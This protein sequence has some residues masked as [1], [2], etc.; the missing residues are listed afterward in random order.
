M[1]DFADR[2]NRLS[3][4][5][6]ELLLERLRRAGGRPAAEPGIPRRADPRRA[7]L[8]FAQRRLWFLDQ[9]KQEG[10]G[11]QIVGAIRLE[12]PLNRAAL[13]QSLEAIVQRHE[14]L[15][16]TIQVV[17]GEPMQV[18]APL[19]ACPLPGIDWSHLESAEQET[20]IKQFLEDE[21]HRGFDLA[22][23]PLLRASLLMRGD[24]DHVLTLAMHHIVADGWSGGVLR[25]ELAEFYRAFCRGQPPQLRE[26]PA[27]YADFAEWQR[28]HLQ[29]EEL[30]QQLTYWRERLEH[31]PA[32]RLPADRPRPESSTRRGGVQERWL[33][34]AHR[35]SLHQFNRHEGV[36]L[37]MT[38]L[39]CFQ[40]LLARYSGQT[41]I[42]VGTPVANRNRSELE[43][44]IGFFVNTLV[45]RTDCSGNPTFRQLLHHVRETAVGA[46]A[47]QDLPFERLVEELHPERD[48]ER[49]PLFQVAFAVQNAPRE[50]LEM[51]DLV[52]SPLVPDV[53]TTR[54]DL[55]LHVWE[56]ERGLRLVA[57]F[58]RD[59]FQPE[60]I[61]R[62]L[63]HLELLIQSALATPE[64]SIW[65]LPLL[66]PAERRQ[67]LSEWNTA[68]SDFA[69]EAGLVELFRRQVCRTPEA[70]SVVS[71]DT[72]FT[73]REL[74]ERSEQIA[75]RLLQHGVGP[76]TPVAL[77]LDPSPE[78]IA[79]TLGI[80]KAGGAYVP[81]DFAAPPARWSDVLV[82][83]GTRLVL[84]QRSLRDR[85]APLTELPIVD[86]DGDL[87]PA[88]AA[89]V[90]F[91]PIRAD[92]LA[93]VM[94]TS[95][96]MGRPKGIAV[97][98]R[99]VVRLVQ[100]TNYVQI[101]PRDVVAQLA[102]YAFDA[103]TFEVWGALLSGARLAIMPKE[104]A[105][106]P[107]QFH[108]H[109][110]HHGT[111][112]VF[113]TTSLFHHLARHDPDIFASLRCL[114]V[115]GEAMDPRIAG[116]V[117]AAGRPQ[118]LV[119]VY[120]P[121]E[122]ATFSTFYAIEEVAADD[123]SVPIG[124]PVSNTEL[125]VLDDRM[126]PVPIGVPGELYLGGDGLARGYLQDPRLTAE[127]F[128]PHLFSDQSGQRLYATGDVVCFRANG[129]LEFLG[130]RDHQ[131]KLRGFRIELDEIERLLRGHPTVEDAAVLMQ[132]DNSQN[133][134]LVACVQSRED[135]PATVEALLRL[136]RASLPS[137]MVPA[138][139][140]FLPEFP[141]NAYGK[142]DRGALDD[143]AFS[144]RPAVA[145]NEG[146]TGTG[147][148]TPIEEAVAEIFAELLSLD[149]V[150]LHTSF[151][152]LGGHSLLATQLASRLRDVFQIELPLS[153]LF[154]TP[155]VAAASAEVEQLLR[156]DQ[157]AVSPPLQATSRQD[158]APA[159]FAQ[160]RLWFLHRFQPEGGAWH[161]PL[162]AELRGPLDI[163]A[164]QCSL[165]EIVRRHEA[166]RTGFAEVS[167]QPFQVIA[168][169]VR[170]PVRIVD[171][172]GLAEPAR[173]EAVRQQAA[174]E[175][176]E[177]FEL[178]TAP[179][180]R[181]C[182]LRLEDE[183]SVLSITLHHIV[184]DGWSLGILSRELAAC[185]EAFVE[186][187]RP[188]LL[189]LP[190]QY[191]DFAEWQR[192]WL[193]ESTDPQQLNYWR[194][195]LADLPLLQL[196]TDHP[197]PATLNEA[198]S[199]VI[200]QLSPELTGQLRALSRQVGTTLYMTML[201]A[202]D[203]LLARYTGQTDIVIGTPIANRNRSE[204]EGLIGFFVNSLVMR[205]D[206]SGD[207][208]FCELLRRVR[209]TALGAYAHQDLPFERLVEELNPE[210]HFN[211][212]PLFQVVFAVQNAWHEPLHLTGLD[213]RPIEFDVATA[214]YDLQLDVWEHA[215]CLQLNAFFNCDLFER[216]TIQ[217]LM[218][219]LETLL[220][221][222]VTDP[223]RRL[224]EFPLLLDQDHQWL[225]ER[226]IGQPI[227]ERP[228]CLHQRFQVQAERTPEAVAVVSADQQLSYGELNAWANRIA[229]CLRERSVGP[230][231]AVGLCVDRTPGLV[232]GILGI[233]KAG[234]AYVPLEPEWPVER[235][236]YILAETKAPVLL[237][238]QSLEGQL[239]P[240][241]SNAATA[242]S[243][244]Q[245][246]CLD[247][248][249][250]SQADAKC[251]ASGVRPENLAYVIY[252]SGSTGHP[253]GVLVTHANVDRLFANTAAWFHFDDRDVWTLFH[254]FAFD[255]S[256]WELWGALLHGGRLVILPYLVS[257][258]PSEFRHWLKQHG[259]TVLNQTPTAFSQL[260]AVTSPD[261][262]PDVRC[263]VFGGEALDPAS[264]GAWLDGKLER[265]RLVN[266]YGITETTVH[267]T[268]S[269][270]TSDAAFQNGSPIG[271]P[272]P[273][274]QIHLLDRWGNQ[275]PIGC[276]GEICVGGAG[277]ARGYVA[278]AVLTA[279]KFIPDP[280]S[281]LPGQ[282][283]YRSG[284][285]ARYR[286]DGSLEFL[287]RCDDQVK[288]RGF[289]VELGE[290]ESELITSDA[291]REAA[292]I[293][294]QEVSGDDRLV[295]YV[296][297][298]IDHPWIRQQLTDEKRR[299]TSHW[300]EL[301]DHVYREAGSSPDPELNLAGW[302]SSY[303]GEPIPEAAMREQIERTV[304]RIQAFQTQRILEIGCGTGLLL[305]RLAPNCVEY[306][307]T[308][309][310]AVALEQL[311]DHLPE[312]VTLWLREADDFTGISPGSIDVVVLNS[313]VQYFPDLDYL[314]RVLEGAAR[315][316][317]SG[318]AIFVGDV[319]SLP[320]EHAFQASVELPRAAD[321]TTLAEVR[322]RI[323]QQLNQENE[324]LIDPSFFEGLAEHLPGLRAIRVE[325]KRGRDHNELTQFRYDVTM[326]F[327][328]AP[329]PSVEVEWLDWREQ[330]W[331]IAEIRH[332]LRRPK[333]RA[334]GL[335]CVDNARS[336]AAVRAVELLQDLPDN[337]VA[338]A[339]EQIKRQVGLQPGVDPELLW[340]LA[341]ELPYRVV[342]RWTGGR[343]PGDF[344]VAFLPVAEAMPLCEPE[345]LLPPRAS[346]SFG[347]DVNTPWQPRFAARLAQDLRSELRQ[348]LP[349][350][351][352]PSAIVVLDRFPLTSRGKLDRQALPPPDMSR[353]GLDTSFAAPRSPLEATLAQIWREVLHVQQVGI[354]DN[355]FDLGGHSL[356]A[357][358]V[359][360]RVRDICRVELPLR[361]L[362]ESPT[363]AELA[364]AVAIHK[365]AEMDN[366]RLA[367]SL[368]RIQ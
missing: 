116:S 340:A 220:R 258:S 241:L 210:R 231:T 168:Q 107:Q 354:H 44:L 227:V 221:S 195:Q 199:T 214:R 237:T 57:T 242:S 283:L 84:T 114:L 274:L 211:R 96:S 331:S 47:H 43:G 87:A 322:E 358:Q 217:R 163:R 332:R 12:G 196:P 134:R 325:P 90:V 58:D 253:K 15:R 71:D 170:C 361:S 109:L 59:L 351:M 209:S 2:I 132:G 169:T 156:A 260:G 268:H 348:R 301:Y 321:S 254:S 346:E 232:A 356:L 238:S 198:G 144:R 289:R 230:E 223:N 20:R 329:L 288:I 83:S 35:K 203:L 18:I 252:T 23:G 207:P 161:V 39:A 341:D 28:S 123:V 276:P 342:I 191:A 175:Q 180:V 63:R 21:Q 91:P 243:Q 50:R 75:R 110:R 302:V 7:P 229:N 4:E 34:D 225:T 128:V 55:E 82:E 52:L 72:S 148:R 245:W 261:D 60:T 333:A 13:E 307:A 367:E 293:H 194:D 314:Q 193:E 189:E 135:S 127:K 17:D 185:Y 172:R 157:F 300:R 303:T 49:N 10:G 366:S 115:G 363:I 94:Y 98:Q 298:D 357:T 250:V 100:N 352:I 265:P 33:S 296:T 299:L 365:A 149:H 364:V 335:S 213:V 328:T 37:Y 22:K 316:V 99:A 349:D 355:F 36:T 38:L 11:Y 313:L 8:S 278:D 318:G 282:R 67:L 215:D 64:A 137:Y 30:Q 182:V 192:R 205:T 179:L 202:F 222:I 56:Q 29:G 24:Q 173:E 145:G 162:M 124:R 126:S 279:E 41:D 264:L 19:A 234:G 142:V 216:T 125:Y 155:S 350:Y 111:S 236:A 165:D 308:D 324:L 136:T 334:W 248:L 347:R 257:R 249:E 362:F 233:L 26:L 339:R 204:L 88:E 277:L 291:V 197:R 326:H 48:A 294:R 46:Y 206:L 118:R 81:L 119:N 164:L 190:I 239:E 103:A 270:L 330:R 147:P 200:R 201:A 305:Y 74:D 138:E 6:R 359:V 121:T 360:A 311:R 284:D 27:Q 40:L 297:A 54:F 263:V 160:Q 159:S 336:L 153:V 271:V 51:A 78:L 319:R 14:V 267:V 154:R 262:L 45:M 320:L 353:P 1:N 151:F 102:N 218:N 101:G 93:Y 69:R 171:L 343:P 108:R 62:L 304:E 5:K 80:L 280:F 226:N 344:D 106:S 235:L 275:V 104:I 315:V 122:N 130:R 186:G 140:V 286:P 246:L 290:I 117:L 105:I 219:H 61:A 184:S 181:C 86:I 113:L 317:R 244:P 187:R 65:E 25:R 152:D 133:R 292:V 269:P 131:V 212:H 120:G 146:S 73:Y 266:M 251:P 176:C 92:N 53:T 309:V 255:F 89:D 312:N 97:S 112:V 143:L 79:A 85:I 345:F 177:A 68:P 247:G 287:G 70:V 158:R 259:V 9:L 295:A 272:I 327:G 178:S 77:A 174:R 188:Q 16:T 167:G 337:T 228:E 273:D 285:L 129:D 141:R 208:P 31:L 76:E 306:L 310:S 3:P 323:R 281:S 32:L 224:S 240:L 183:R 66:A 256:V 42:V 368:A 95:G 150:P 166:L 338:E 139:V